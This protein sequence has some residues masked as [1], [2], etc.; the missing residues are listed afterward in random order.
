MEDEHNEQDNK[1]LVHG[2]GQANKNRVENNTKFQDG[3]TDYLS[4]D[5]IGTGIRRGGRFFVPF[6]VVN[7]MVTA[8]GIALCGGWLRG[9]WVK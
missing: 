3:N 5:R 9:H 2:Q 4:G 6:L 7:V 8:G 1:V